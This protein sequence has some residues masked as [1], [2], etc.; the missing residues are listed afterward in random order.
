MFDHEKYDCPEAYAEIICLSCEN[1]DPE[2]CET[3]PC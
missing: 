2:I 3:C 1:D